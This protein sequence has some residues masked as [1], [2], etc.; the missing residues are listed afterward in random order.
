MTKA[1]DFIEI[2]CL[3]D[4]FHYEWHYGTEQNI[5]KYTGTEVPVPLIINLWKS[6]FTASTVGILPVHSGTVFTL[7]GS[8]SG[9]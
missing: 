8:E 2:T 4:I 1:I 5:V 9:E 3:G 7:Q 6:D